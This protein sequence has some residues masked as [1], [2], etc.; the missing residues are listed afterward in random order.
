MYR[1]RKVLVSSMRKMDRLSI[2]ILLGIK[3]MVSSL[4]GVGMSRWMKES[5][6]RSCPSA[7][8]CSRS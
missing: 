3:V 2:D 1:V 6:I 5:L 8:H 7:V 4:K